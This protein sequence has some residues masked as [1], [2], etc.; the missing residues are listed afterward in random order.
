MTGKENFRPLFSRK[1]AIF[2][3][4]IAII[5][6]LVLPEL[7]KAQPTIPEDD[8]FCF[9]KQRNGWLDAVVISGG[10]PT[11]QK[12]LPEFIA[13]IKNMGFSVKLDTNGTHPEV[14]TLLFKNNLLDFV[15]MDIKNICKPKE[16]ETVTGNFRLQSYCNP[17]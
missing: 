2:V 12:D 9:L 10:E 5:L 8:I 16:Y 6:S 11:I 7:I 13:K 3:V 4:P 14:L 15:A 1:A 17:F